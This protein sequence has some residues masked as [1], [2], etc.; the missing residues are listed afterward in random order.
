MIEK[1]LGFT[2]ER[3]IQSLDEPDIRPE[4]AIHNL[5]DSEYKIRNVCGSKNEK[6][7]KQ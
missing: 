4:F 6:L 3:P 1:R 7:T 5:R 2:L